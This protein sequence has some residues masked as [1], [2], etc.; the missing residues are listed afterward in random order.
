ML[1]N[2]CHLGTNEKASCFFCGF[3]FQDQYGVINYDSGLEE[4]GLMSE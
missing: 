4:E 3:F 2:D 1:K